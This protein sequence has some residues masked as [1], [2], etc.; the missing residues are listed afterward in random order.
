MTTSQRPHGGRSPAHDED[1]NSGEGSSRPVND[2][3]ATKSPAQ[4]PDPWRRSYYA[5]Q[6]MGTEEQ[7]DDFI[8][9]LGEPPL[10]K[11]GLLN[12]D[13]RLRFVHLPSYSGAPFRAAFIVVRSATL[14]TQLLGSRFLSGCPDSGQTSP[15]IICNRGTTHSRGAPHFLFFAVD[16]LSSDKGR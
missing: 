8:Q 7:M 13:D 12:E 10:S 3:F 1:N 6:R 4:L 2:G 16:Y 11:G 14:T 5:R 9:R 15:H